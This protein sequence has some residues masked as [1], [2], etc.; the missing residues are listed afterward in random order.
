MASDIHVSRE[1]LAKL[2]KLSFLLSDEV[3]KP[4]IY[5]FFKRLNGDMK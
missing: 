3:T 1:L 5:E 2:Q 4:T